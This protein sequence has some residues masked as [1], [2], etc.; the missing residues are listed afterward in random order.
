MKAYKLIVVSFLFLLINGNTI[1]QVKKNDLFILADTINVVPEN[2]FLEMG[3]EGP[4]HYFTY[5]CKCIPPFDRYTT[6]TYNINKTKVVKSQHKPNFNFVSWKEL[7]EILY[8]EGKG[9]PD[10]YNIFITE[11]LPDKS[12]RTDNVRLVLFPPPIM[13][14]SIVKP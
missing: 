6:F 8:K 10:K 7:A 2:K 11:V 3:S 12:Y 5:L 1:A 9:I 13:D 4:M 14:F